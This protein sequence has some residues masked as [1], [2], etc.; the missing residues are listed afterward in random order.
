MCTQTHLNLLWDGKQRLGFGWS[1]KKTLFRAFQPAQA[2]EGGT[3]RR[4]RIFPSMV[5]GW[6]GWIIKPNVLLV[7]VIISIVTDTCG[8]V[9]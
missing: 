7:V 6:Y 4:W 3:T 1:M 8:A 9:R 5:A 2:Q